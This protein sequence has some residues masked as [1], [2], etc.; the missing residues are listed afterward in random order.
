MKIENSNVVDLSG[1]THKLYLEPDFKHNS[2]TWSSD[3][4]YIWYFRNNE[5]KRELVRMDTQSWEAEIVD[6]IDLPSIPWSR[7]IDNDLIYQCITS[8]I[9]DSSENRIYY[10]APGTN[11]NTLTLMSNTPMGGN[12]TEVERNLL[13]TIDRWS[14]SLERNGVIRLVGYFP[15]L[16][17]YEGLYLI[18]EQK[19]VRFRV[20]SQVNPNVTIGNMK[21]LGN[22]MTLFQSIAY[23][24]SEDS[25]VIVGAKL[26][27]R[28]SVLFLFNPLRNEYETLDLRFD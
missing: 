21:F 20:D 14:L 13:P 16:K 19:P 3:G 9:F 6:V 24:G 2:F 4:K 25:S 11:A 15:G 12:S 17:R 27:D 8:V 1:A 22:G 10:L 5:G 7:S 23:N 26:Y 18:D 28:I